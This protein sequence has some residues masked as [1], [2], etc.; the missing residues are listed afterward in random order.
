MLSFYLYF[1]DFSV[2]CLQIIQVLVGE[3]VEAGRKKE[4]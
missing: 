2:L 4:E 3:G 1:Y